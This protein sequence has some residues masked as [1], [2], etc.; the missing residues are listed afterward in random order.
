MIVARI[1]LILACLIVNVPA[2][3][4]DWDTLGLGEDGRGC[5]SY[6]KGCVASVK[7]RYG[8]VL[9]TTTD[10]GDF[11][12]SV[13]QKHDRTFQGYSVTLQGVYAL[14]KSDNVLVALNSGGMACPMELY[15]VQIRVDSTHAVSRS[16]GT[17]TDYYKAYVDKDALLVRMP[18][19]FNP[20]HF[21]DLSKK[22]R[23]EVEQRKGTVFRWSNSRLTEAP[24]VK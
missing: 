5:A 15:I 11:R 13:N 17:C 8:E 18:A 19:Y 10:E 2:L 16:F 21:K 3:S 20:M 22:E 7:T 1:V 14:S 9:F 12:L 23:K 24:D 4:S 6:D